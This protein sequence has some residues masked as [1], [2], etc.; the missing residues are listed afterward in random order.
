MNIQTQIKISD[1][2]IQVK[3]LSESSGIG[4]DV[5]LKEIEQYLRMENIRKVLM[6]TSFVSEEK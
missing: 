4:A 5:I 1:L 3:Q 2:S 6:T